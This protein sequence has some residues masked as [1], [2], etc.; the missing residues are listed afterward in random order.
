M[1]IDD[2]LMQEGFGE[3]VDR[4]YELMEETAGHDLVQEMEE[5]FGSEIIAKEW[6]YST[7][8]ALGGKRPYDYC[9]EGKQEELSKVIVRLS[10]GVF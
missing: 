10:N 6:F 1:G 9:V 4:L 2:I 3:A 7:P 8:K 5:F